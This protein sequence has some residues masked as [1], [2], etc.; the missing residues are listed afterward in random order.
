MKNIRLLILIF[1]GI[2]FLQ[3]C[4]LKELFVDVNT[5]DSISSVSVKPYILLIGEPIISL[6]VGDSYNE[7]GVQASEVKEGGTDLQYT[8][9][10][11]AVDPATIG[12]YTVEY[13][14]VNTFGWA[15]Y[16][17]RSVLVHDGTPYGEEIGYDDYAKGFEFKAVVAKS[18]INGYWTITGN[19]VQEKNAEKFTMYFADKGDK[20]YEVVNGVHPTKGRYWG[21]AIRVYKG[22]QGATDDGLFFTITFLNDGVELTKTYLWQSKKL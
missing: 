7:L 14:A 21:N 9:E 8:I 18:T 4:Q 6:Q 20:T 10:K 17:Y 11:G 19:L 2:I 3:S 15:S 12:F 13:K 22:I 5:T 1:I 16:S